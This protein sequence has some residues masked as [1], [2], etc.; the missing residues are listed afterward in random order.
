MNTELINK[1]LLKNALS[2]LEKLNGENFEEFIDNNFESDSVEDMAEY[3]AQSYGLENDDEIT[4]LTEIL[5][6][7]FI[8]GKEMLTKH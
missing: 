8:L 4:L 6:K 1:D 5:I 2:D 3:I 7:G